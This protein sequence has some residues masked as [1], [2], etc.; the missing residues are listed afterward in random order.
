MLLAHEPDVADAVAGD[1][2]VHLQLSGHSHGGQINVPG[3]VQY[4]LPQFGRKYPF[5]SYRVGD[6]FLHTSRG[7]GT[8][9]VPVRFRSP[10]EVSEITLVRR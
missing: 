5:G 4:V 3:L 2:R 6:L 1:G 7:L 8:T 9:R 10:P